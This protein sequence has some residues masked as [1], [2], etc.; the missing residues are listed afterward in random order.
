MKSFQEYS[1]RIRFRLD[2]RQIIDKKEYDRKYRTVQ[3]DKK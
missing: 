2:T 1:E 3:N